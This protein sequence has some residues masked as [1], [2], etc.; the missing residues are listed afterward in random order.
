MNDIRTQNMEQLSNWLVAHFEKSFRAKQ[1]SEWLWKKNAASFDDMMNLPLALR[2]AMKQDFSLYKLNIIEKQLSTD[3]SIKYAFQ[4]ADGNIIETVLIPSRNRSTVCVS[5]QVGCGLA[6][7]F[8]AT[9]NLGFTRNLYAYEMY[10]QV[11]IANEESKLHFGHPITNLV[12]MGMGEPLLNY[13]NVM[14]A[15]EYVSTSAGLGM[16]KDRITLSTCG[17]ADGIRRLAD[18]NVKIHLAL[19]LHTADNSQRTELM[20]INKTNSIS[21]I[22]DALAYY[23][24]KTESRISIE[25]LLLDKTNDSVEHAR[26]LAIFCKRFP[27]KINL[28]EYNPHPYAKFK[29]SEKQRVKAF[30]DFLESK[31]I[32]V[33]LRLS[34]GKDIAAACGQLANEKKSSL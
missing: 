2:E 32:L 6:C 17:I 31:N 21:L 29:D 4:L 9:A 25:Y 13:D 5:S 20:P 28:I 33:N 34:K 8:C 15:I 16:S 27:V 14:K 11:F 23:F 18:D 19:S 10:E 22:S 12:W 3:G 24:Q 30:V 26:M 1:I 7:L